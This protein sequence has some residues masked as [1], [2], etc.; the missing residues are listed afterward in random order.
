MDQG[1]TVRLEKA[2]K[3]VRRFEEELDKHVVCPRFYSLCT[4]NTSPTK[5]LKGLETAK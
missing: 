4:A 1:V 5:L 3:E 2:E